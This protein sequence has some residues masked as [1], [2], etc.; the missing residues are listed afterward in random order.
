MEG[1]LSTGVEGG[2]TGEVGRVMGWGLWTPASSSPIGGREG[3]VKRE[4]GRE[5]EKEKR[6][7]E[8]ERE[9]EEKDLKHLLHTCT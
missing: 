4:E 6:R 8:R 9:R 2:E 1:W 7:G 3:K 5:M